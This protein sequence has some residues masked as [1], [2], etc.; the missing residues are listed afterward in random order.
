VNRPAGR[1]P[2]A[3][4]PNSETGDGGLDVVTGAFS[5]SGR[6]IADALRESG[7]R[8][9][10]LTGHPE[11]APRDTPV[12][13]RPLQFDDP[14]ELVSSLE[15]ATT[16]YNTYWVRFAHDRTDHER[17]VANSR[18]LFEAAE[19]AGVRRIVHVSIT[20]PSLD[21]PFPYFRGK[22]EVEQSLA[23]T[24]LSYA[25]LR[26]AILFGGD[27]VLLNNIAWLLRHLPVFAV[28]GSGD[29]RIRGI[30]IDDLAQLCVEMGRGSDRRT[31][32]AV[33]PESP[34][35][36]ELVTS[37]RDAVGSRARIIRVP[38]FLIPAL[39]RVLGLLLR[40]V[41]LTSDEYGAMA[42]GLADTTGPA[43]GPT[44]L[45]DWL[46]QQGPALG[47]H[48]ANELHRHFDTPHPLTVPSHA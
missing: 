21:S 8:V 43:T 17:A 34:T 37:I 36:L 15:G 2:P 27:G 26:P 38:S 35:F 10:T 1:V 19:R 24:G 9:R 6:A 46:R 5:Y 13:V 33:G 3:D 16:L 20:N 31:L 4:R 32:D 23:Q 44:A 30:H 45:S 47:R 12:E 28:G 18:L 48:Y 29:Y 42:A 40:D 39:A 14:A 41:L 25:I 7:R 22:A 11:R